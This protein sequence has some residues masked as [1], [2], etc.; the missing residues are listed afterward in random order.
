MTDFPASPATQGQ[1]ASRSAHARLHDQG[2]Q[3]P[4]WDDYQ[5]IRQQFSHFRNW[6]IWVYLAWASQPADRR[7]PPTEAELAEEVLGCS[8]RSIRN[9]KAREYGEQ[10]SIEQAVAYLQAAPL[11]RYR[12]DIFD[13][14]VAVARTPDPKAH[15]DRKL[16]LE[17]TGDYTPRSTVDQDI[18]PNVQKWLREL[19]EAGPDDGN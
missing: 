4:W 8:T 10:A 11:L 17:M 13:A 9:W 7:Q 19:R 1:P 5:A 6:R 18:G 14:L 16:A 12:R 2:D 15:S 3:W